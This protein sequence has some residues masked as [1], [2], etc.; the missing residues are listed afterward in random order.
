MR[1]EGRKTD[2]GMALL[3]TLVLVLIIAG[4]VAVIQARSL[5]AQSILARL[6]QRHQD[7]LAEDSVF[8]R[9]RLLVADRLT[10][11]TGRL[12]LDGEAIEL[13]QAGVTVSLSVQ[14]S[15]GLINIWFAQPDVLARLPGAPT[16]IGARRDRLIAERQAGAAFLSTGQVLAA[17]GFGQP[18]RQAAANLATLDGMTGGVNEATAP[19]VLRELLLQHAPGVLQSGQAR[20]VRIGIAPIR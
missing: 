17:L 2:R 7:A 9:A 11:E 6:A 13:E 1:L 4:L 5:G 18:E 20:S 19:V 16:D 15:G 14:D 10:S 3:M 12:P 8:E